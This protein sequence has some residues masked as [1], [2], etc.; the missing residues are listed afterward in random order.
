MGEGLCK[1]AANRQ[2]LINSPAPFGH[3][4]FRVTNDETGVF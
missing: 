1:I 3:P 4:P 2:E